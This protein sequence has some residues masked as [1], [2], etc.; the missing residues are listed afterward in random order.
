MANLLTEILRRKREDVAELLR[1]RTEDSI[2]SNALRV[3]K[4]A[5]PHRLRTTLAAKNPELK[6]IAEYKRRSP[7][8]GIIREDLPPADAASIYQKAGACA[9][10]VLTEK[11]FFGGSIEDLLQ[12]R[13]ATSL[14]LLRKDFII[15]PVQIF[16]AAESGADAV[17]LIAAALDDK[18]LRKLRLITEEELGLDTLVE[19]HTREE[20]ER[21]TNC[22][23]Q[24]I[25]IN[26]RDL[27]TFEVSL[28][29]SE[30]LVRYAPEKALLVS[31]SGLKTGEDLSRLRALGFDGFLI[32]ETLMQSN[33]P[34]DALR[35]LVEP[36]RSRPAAALQSDM[37]D[38]N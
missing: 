29:I 25:G 8:K 4:K 33:N 17:L 26:N 12:I 38:A 6:I 24:I 14:P 19:V 10:S 31:E 32:G 9:I 21:G 20:M 2:R 30:A 36:R 11:H 7:S 28:S 18:T 15:H 1:A 3:R 23:A 13:A 34:G 22:G 5:E 27:T 37:G 16:E 35:K